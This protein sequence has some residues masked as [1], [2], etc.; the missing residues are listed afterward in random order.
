MENISFLV[1][2]SRTIILVIFAKKPRPI[3]RY[4]SLLLFLNLSDRFVYFRRKIVEL[5]EILAWV[6]VD[7][8]KE[9][10]ELELTHFNFLRNGDWR[11]TSSIRLCTAS[12]LL[13][14]VR[15]PPLTLCLIELLACLGWLLILSDHQSVDVRRLILYFLVWTRVG[16]WH[17]R[18]LHLGL[19]SPSLVPRLLWTGGHL[20]LWL[21]LLFLFVY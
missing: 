1:S 19:R 10:L 14:S 18:L 5:R 6:F 7:S 15:L 11:R 4:F 8:W 17:R 16:N 13:H 3:D 12:H 9:I 21:W 20:T 2:L